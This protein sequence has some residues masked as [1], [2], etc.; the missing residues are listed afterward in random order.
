M[1]LSA[2]RFVGCNIRNPLRMEERIEDGGLRIE[3]G[4]LKIED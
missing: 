3:D 1:R 2:P 4:G